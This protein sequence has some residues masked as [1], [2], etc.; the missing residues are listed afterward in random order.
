MENAVK[1]LYMVAALLI[2]VMI[3]GLLV[4]LF[5]TGS[6]FGTNY[7]LKKQQEQIDNFNSKFEV[8]ATPLTIDAE[9]SIYYAGNNIF[10]IITVANMAYDINE[11]NG[12]DNK[13]RVEVEI[14]GL[15]DNL[16]I[17]VSLDLEGE[18]K[19]KKNQFFKS[20][21][22]GVN[23]ADVIDMNDV[24]DYPDVREATLNT[25]NDLK[26]PKDRTIYKIYFECKEIH[27]STQS[28]K[29]DKLVFKAVENTNYDD[30]LP[31]DPV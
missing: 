10:D 30:L 23:S 12:N 25:R 28:G 7:E 26:I 5:R 9:S 21:L 29:V 17:G 11:R 8:Y 2:A 27:Y 24:L 20:K 19:L 4:Y 14:V 15:P 6:L 18:N 1:A 3:M 22:D 16:S 31:A 13:N